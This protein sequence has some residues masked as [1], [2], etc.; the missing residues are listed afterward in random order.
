[1]S[2]L[3]KKMHM[4]MVESEAIEKN[5]T[6]G[7]GGKNSYKAVSEAAV[8]NA[9]KPLLK[10]HGLVIFPVG[11]SIK[12]NFQEYQ[13]KYGTTQRF[14]SELHAKYKIVD[15]DTGEFEILETVGYGADS[16]DKGSGKAMTYAYKALIQKTFCL[17][18]GEDTDNEHSDDIEKKNSHDNHRPQQP[19]N[20]PPEWQ[21]QAE[22]LG[23]AGVI[24]VN[25]AKRIFAIA[26]GNEALIKTVIKK[27]GYT[28]T[29]DITLK[30]YNQICT[31]IEKGR[32]VM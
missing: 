28:G 2:S 26:G 9:I 14:I 12:E 31:E 32:E 30:D 23:H 5:M 19:A 18:S 24:S 11:V 16:Q 6:V 3:Y 8:L 17:F 25:Q 10:K 15:I 20:L 21:K 27:Y 29:K 7:D 4:V 13:G 1:M 22:Q